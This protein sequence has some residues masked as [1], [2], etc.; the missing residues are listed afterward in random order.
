M[1]KPIPGCLRD[2]KGFANP[3]PLF[4]RPFPDAAFRCRRSSDLRMAIGPAR[5]GFGRNLG[6]VAAATSTARA[7][8]PLVGKALA[9]SLPL[10]TL[11]LRSLLSGLSLRSLCFQEGGCHQDRG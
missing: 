6:L 9:Y 4:S 3:I 8:P 5:S 2:F 7:L 11:N 1:A 10:L